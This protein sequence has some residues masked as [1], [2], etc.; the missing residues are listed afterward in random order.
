MRVT[1]SQGVVAGGDAADALAERW[2]RDRPATR[3]LCPRW[4]RRRDQGPMEPTADGREIPSLEV[5]EGSATELL[6][7]LPADDATRRRRGFPVA[8]Y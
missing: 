1:P 2:D 6:A 8:S 7:A 5:W 3:H 4:R